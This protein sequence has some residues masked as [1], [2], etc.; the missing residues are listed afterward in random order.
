MDRFEAMSMLL[1]VVDRGNLSAASRSLKIPLPTLSRKITDL[2]TLLGTKLLTRTTRKIALTDAGAT[3][4]DAARRI[5]EQVDEAERQASGEFAMPKGE[6]VITAPV[7]FGRLHVL[8]VVAD[9]LAAFPAINVRLMLADR[10]ID[11]VDEH[12]DMAVRIGNL[13]DSAMVATR[14]G[15]VRRVVCGSPALFAG[16]GAPKEPADLLGLPCISVE[17]LTPTAGWQFQKPGAAKA[18]D[19]LISPRLSVTTTEAAA[20]AAIRGAGVT[21]LLYYQVAGAVA[22]GALKLVLE[23]FEPE[24]APIHLV[25]LA[26]GQMPLKMRHFLDFAAPRLRASVAAL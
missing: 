9:F 23:D 24:P 25:H 19:V 12:V 5:L 8:P 1:E 7:Q 10:N 26:R 17:I 14:I 16:R 2:E 13:P 15:S 6:L 3:Y 4:V 22:A 21:R 20:E 18:I 11:L